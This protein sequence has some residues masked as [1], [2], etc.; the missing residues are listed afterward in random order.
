MAAYAD[1]VI[2]GS[3]FV[4]VLLDHPDDRAAGLRALTALTEDLAEGVRARWL[5]CEASSSLA[6]ARTSASSSAGSICSSPWRLQRQQR[7][8]RGPARHTSSTRPS[9]SPRPLSTD[10]DGE[11]YSLADDTDKR[12]TLVFFGYTNCP[13]ICG[14][15]DGQPG[16]GA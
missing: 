6:L 7:Q 3:A 11:P 5:R 9:R 10:T 1:G 14:V 16:L 8:G 12:L 13:D 2:V 4:R 15:G